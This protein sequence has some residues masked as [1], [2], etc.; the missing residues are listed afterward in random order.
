MGI[1]T[2]ASTRSPPFRTPQ[3]PSLHLASGRPRCSG[4]VTIG[5]SPPQRPPPRH[6]RCAGSQRMPGDDVHFGVSDRDG[7]APLSST[8]SPTPALEPRGGLSSQVARYLE[9]GKRGG[10]CLLGIVAPSVSHTSHLPM[11]E[12][13]RV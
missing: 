7:V 3:S 2:V 10:L 4:W 6:R 5:P 9:R 13:A 11:C 1:S 12:A 8:L